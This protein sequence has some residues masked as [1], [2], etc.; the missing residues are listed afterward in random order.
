MNQN[1]QQIVIIND[2][3]QPYEAALNGVATAVAVGITIAVPVLLLA[4]L[5]HW[6]S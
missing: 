2:S 4:L 1:N 5:V 3:E 6:I